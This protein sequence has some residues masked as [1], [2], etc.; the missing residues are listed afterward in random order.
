MHL[1]LE[2]FVRFV[3]N[4]GVLLIAGGGVTGRVFGDLITSLVDDALIPMTYDGL[5][6]WVPKDKLDVFFVQDKHRS[7]VQ[8]VSL[9]FNVFV[10]LVS[11]LGIYLIAGIVLTNVS[12]FVR[13]HR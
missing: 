5:T 3:A 2:G 8:W 9:A 13:S 11:T 7:G 4:N 1:P 10:F 6:K 12:K